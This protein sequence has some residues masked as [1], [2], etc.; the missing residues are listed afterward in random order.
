MVWALPQWNKFIANEKCLGN[1]HLIG[2][3][4]NNKIKRGEKIHL[5]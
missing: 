3:L 1:K 5:M 2:L 4:A